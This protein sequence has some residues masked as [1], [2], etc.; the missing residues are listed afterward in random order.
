MPPLPIVLIG[1]MLGYHIAPCVSL[2]GMDL[3]NV[4]IF[5]CRYLH[6]SVVS[7]Q[8]ISLTRPSSS[9]LRASLRYAGGAQA[10]RS[11]FPTVTGRHETNVIATTCHG[12]G[13][14]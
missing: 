8:N 1:S 4:F 6:T 7:G 10:W 13:G 2:G 3:S 5:T 11:H 14:R 9:R 12:Q